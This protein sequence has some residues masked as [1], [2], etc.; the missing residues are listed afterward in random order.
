MAEPSTLPATGGI[1][2]TLYAGL[3]LAALGLV[4]MGFGV[5]RLALER[6]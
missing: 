3:A 2:Y 4:A 1:S 5:K 6:A